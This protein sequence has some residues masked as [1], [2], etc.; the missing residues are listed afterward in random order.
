MIATDRLRVLA[1]GAI[2]VLIAFLVML[3]GVLA[4]QQT[5]PRN[6][7]GLTARTAAVAAMNEQ[8]GREVRGQ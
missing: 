8:A 4:M 5:L 3:C 1:A 6:P 2:M 7:D